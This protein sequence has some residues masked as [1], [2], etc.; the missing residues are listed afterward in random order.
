MI[1]SFIGFSW[2]KI[3]FQYFSNKTVEKVSRKN[4]L[5]FLPILLFVEVF[6]RHLI[7]HNFRTEIGFH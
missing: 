1:F 4:Q 3:N 5:I 7:E 2:K 6:F